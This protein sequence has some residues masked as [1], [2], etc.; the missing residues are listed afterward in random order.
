MELTIIR[1]VRAPKCSESPRV[2]TFSIP[3]S[4]MALGSER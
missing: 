3:A 1:T 2:E 4:A